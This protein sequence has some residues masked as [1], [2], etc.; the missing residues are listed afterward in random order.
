MGRFRATMAT[1]PGG[2]L[3]AFACLSLMAMQG[4]SEDDFTGVSM[5]EV[6]ASASVLVSPREGWAVREEA[7]AQSLSAVVLL[8]EAEFVTKVHASCRCPETGE[9]SELGESESSTGKP[10]SEKEEEK[11]EPSEKEEEKKEGLEDQ[12][13]QDKK[14][15]QPVSRWRRS[16]RRRMRLSQRRARQRKLQSN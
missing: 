6:P 7:T 5:L 15:K 1:R 3:L 8:G 14:E 9:E 16:R 4:H 2:V 13:K 10:P 11:K 12:G